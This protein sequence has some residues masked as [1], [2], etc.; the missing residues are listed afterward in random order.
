M[1]SPAILRSAVII[2]GPH[3]KQPNRKRHIW[4]WRVGCLIAGLVIGWTLRGLF[5]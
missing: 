1:N 5:I 2:D 3:L 4:P